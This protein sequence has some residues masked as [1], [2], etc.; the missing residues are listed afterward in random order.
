MQFFLKEENKALWSQVQSFA[1]ANDDQSLRS[2]VLEAQRMTTAQRNLR[3]AT[4]GAT[5]EGKNIKPGDAVL[6]LLGAAGRDPTA[7]TDADKFIPT[8][9]QDGLVTAF[10][11]GPH[12]CVGREI[13]I[14]FIVGMVKLAA[15]L[16]DLRPAPGLMGTVK[17]I[18]VGSERCY[19]N[20]SWSYLSF[21][22]SSKFGP[23]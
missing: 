15:G 9:K 20:D 18:Q 12:D 14:T 17:T 13:A 8:R 23:S 1:A 22:A 10:S 11:T 16:K 19:L 4:Q 6:L 21:D 2:Y 7:V 3:I 5:L